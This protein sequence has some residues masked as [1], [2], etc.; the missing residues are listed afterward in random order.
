MKDYKV[1]A[2][3]FVPSFDYQ[4]NITMEMRAH[5]AVD[6]ANKVEKLLRS[7]GYRLPIADIAD[8]RKQEVS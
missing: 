4:K 2:K 3:V 7:Q 1:K 6:A 8:L 5:N